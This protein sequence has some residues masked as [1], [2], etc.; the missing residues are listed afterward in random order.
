MSALTL[1][2]LCGGSLALGQTVPG[3]E[4]CIDAIV[5][6]NVSAPLNAS[7][8]S[9]ATASALA[10]QYYEQ[11]T[12]LEGVDMCDHCACSPRDSPFTI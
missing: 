4:P 3:S 10:K 12:P 7:I 11:Q 2:C 1:A 8:N 5:A 9:M 6:L